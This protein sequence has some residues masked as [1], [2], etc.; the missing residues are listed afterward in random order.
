MKHGSPLNIL[1]EMGFLS[2][3]PELQ[4]NKSHL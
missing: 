4:K 1:E 2:T 3:G